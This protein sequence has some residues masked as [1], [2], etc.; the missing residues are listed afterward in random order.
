MGP[1]F[2]MESRMIAQSGRADAKGI[3]NLPVS[4]YRTEVLLN[5]PPTFPES[6]GVPAQDKFGLETTKFLAV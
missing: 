1:C 4:E 5:I 6:G 3:A 2:G